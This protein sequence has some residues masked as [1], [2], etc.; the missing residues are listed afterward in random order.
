MKLVIDEAVIRRAVGE[1]TFARGRSYAGGGAVLD[2]RW[3]AATQ[4]LT[5]QV[6]GV[7]ERPYAAVAHLGCTP[8][9]RLRTFRGSCTC[10]VGV[11]CKHAVA[12]VLAQARQA[13]PP[14]SWER[15]LAA[16]TAPALSRRDDTS[17]VALQFEL[18]PGQLHLRPVLPGRNGGWV[19]SG[20][21]WPSLHYYGGYGCARLRPDQ[22]AVLR[23]IQTFDA[24]T[25]SH[26]FST[27][28]RPIDLVTFRSR[29]LW[30][31]LADA[32]TTG[33][34]LVQAGQ[35]A[36]SVVL[37]RDGVGIAVD[38]TRDGA[39]VV[40]TPTFG[41]QAFSVEHV[42][43]GDPVHGV[44]WR[45][46]SGS[47]TDLHLAALDGEIGIPLREWIH[48]G[49]LRVP[50]AD[51]P[52]FR[53]DYYPRLRRLVAVTRSTG[54]VDLPQVL[55]PRLALTV[56]YDGARAVELDW[57]WRYRLDSEVRAEPLWP[58]GS[59]DT[60]RDEAVEARLRAAVGEVLAPL[61]TAFEPTIG[62]CRLAASTVLRD[63]AAVQFAEALLPELVALPGLDVETLGERVDYRELSGSTEIAFTDSGTGERDWFDLAVTVSIGGHDLPFEQLFVAL[64]T[65]QSHLILGDGHYLDLDRPELK[66]L[67]RVIAEARAL[68]DA[69]PRT[70]RV[71][72]LQAGLWADLDEL[73]PLTGGAR[74]WQQA[75]GALTDFTQLAE[76]SAPKMLEAQ[77][78][79][80]QQDGLRWLSFLYTHGLGGVLADD[81]GLGKTVQI[82]ALIGHVRETRG[83]VA[84]FLIVAPT[85]V[86][87]N[88]V[89]ECQRF[90]PGLRVRMISETA[91]RR[92]A[93]LRDLATD[94]DIVV[95]S[96]TLFRLEFEKYDE[97]DWAAL[98]LDE[99]QAA[100][101]HLSRNYRC[102]RALRAPVKFA[103][104]GT[105][106]ENHLGELW[107]ILSIT[108]P[109]LF[110]AMNRFD[111]LYRRPIERGRDTERLAELRRRIRPVLLRRT[112]HEVAAELPPKQEQVVEV[113]LHPR[114]RRAY[115]RLLHRER[116]KVLSLLDDLDGNRFEILRSLTLLRQASLDMALVDPAARPV[117]SSK[118][119]VLAEMLQGIVADGH[120]TLV[121][122]Q[123]TRYLGAAAHRLDTAGIGYCYL[124][125]ST[126]RR[127]DVIAEFKDGAAPVFLISLKA[128]GV[129]LN[130]TE[131]DYCVLL[132]P[133]WNPAVEAQA[134]DRAHRI[135]QDKTVMVYRLVAKD[136]I[137]EKVAAL[138]ERKAALFADVLGDGAF[139]GGALTAA[140]IRAMLS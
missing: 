5:G 68:Q 70:V 93:E 32:Q 124:D 41:G 115:E 100:K 114:H 94:A 47:R 9:G 99:A 29:R 50:V 92:G 28:S 15:R 44:C 60:D 7:A 130:L 17:E 85:S 107:S 113:E 123:F 27:A 101:N 72:R 122:S 137:E 30:D 1:Q 110:P 120:R 53:R 103:I 96:Y 134:V 46:V 88:W 77:L 36:G 43:L 10:P 61:P 86:M 56:R 117:P 55:P 33:I 131:A 13:A 42:L 19:R 26:Q 112:K 106:M 133:W 67:A 128:G 95:T 51:E 35:R 12:I 136:T 34:P 119:D 73:G 80:Y 102:G 31:L 71:G 3:D 57:H 139:S 135:G 6:R 63:I 14:P 97:I 4:R 116:Q 75:V 2:V 118:L 40:L 84:P 129:G 69:P 121:F 108:A 18:T 38:A 127:A 109:G 21:S 24:S 105:P 20:I 39:D 132:D 90:A 52:R 98:V 87:S 45:Q 83:D 22:L 11:D 91:G 49:P 54:A 82:L 25:G 48:A 23:E 66:E 16:L 79:P 64:A 62:G 37:H 65:E 125:G 81:M 138:K 78:R 89:N 104:T 140:D 111:E 126:R 58:A 76:V 59:V 8:D 74:E